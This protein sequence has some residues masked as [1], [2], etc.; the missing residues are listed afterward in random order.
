MFLHR[1]WAKGHDHDTAARN[2]FWCWGREI[3][4]EGRI[5]LCISLWE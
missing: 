1:V 4:F 3:L 2:V 5:L